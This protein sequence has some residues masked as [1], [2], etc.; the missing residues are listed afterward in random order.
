MI[1]LQRKYLKKDNS[2]KAK[3]ENDNSEKGHVGKLYFWNT[4]LNTDNPELKKLKRTNWKRNTSEK[5]QIR[6]G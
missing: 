5:G 2:E 6:N 1:I 4:N 3:S